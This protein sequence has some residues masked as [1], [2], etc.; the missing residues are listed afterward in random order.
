[1]DALGSMHVVIASGAL[2]RGKG[3]VILI[4]GGFLVLMLSMA[5]VLLS[6]RRARTAAAHGTP[7]RGAPPASTPSQF[8]IIARRRALGPSEARDAPKRGPPREG[9]RSRPR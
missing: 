4:L 5:W 8:A 9:D 6:A 1:M 3:P 2:P 7:R